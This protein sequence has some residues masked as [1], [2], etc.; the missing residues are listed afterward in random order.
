[1]DRTT[2]QK[3]NKETENINFNTKN[4]LHQKISIV[5]EYY[6]ISTAVEYML[7]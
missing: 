5:V 6:Y 1:M 7:F 4:Q 3:I 2:R